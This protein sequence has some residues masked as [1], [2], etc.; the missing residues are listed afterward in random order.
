MFLWEENEDTRRN[1]G[2]SKQKKNFGFLVDKRE[3]MYVS[4]SVLLYFR[5]DNKK[6]AHLDI[7]WK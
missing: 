7:S 3:F 5:Q 6:R 4:R 1:N 2:Q